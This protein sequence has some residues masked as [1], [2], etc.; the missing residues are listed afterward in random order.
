MD[1]TLTDWPSALERA[2]SEGLAALGIPDEP[3][4]RRSVWD[5]VRAYTWVRRDGLV[6]DR[7]HWKLLLEPQVPWERAFPLE[8]KAEVKRAAARFR[9]L[10]DPQPFAD[11]EETLDALA[12]RHLLGVLSNSPF[13][14]PTLKRF[15]LARRFRAIVS[16][17]D[18]F[19][20]PHPRAYADACQALGVEHGEAV[21]VGDSFANDVE[22]ALAAGLCPVWV[23][24]FADGYPLPEGV[25]RVT[26]LSALPGLL[27]RL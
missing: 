27:A 17:D 15:G 3:L 14:A 20:K 21:Y 7:A 23:D 8:P 10:L 4:A 22:G 6:V 11:A 1:D 5:E 19:R 24:R 18:P 16:P 12:G 26:S 2:I 13:A 25:R 9:E